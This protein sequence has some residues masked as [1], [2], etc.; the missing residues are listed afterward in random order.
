MNTSYVASLLERLGWLINYDKSTLSPATRLDFLG[1]TVDTRQMKFFVPALKRKNFRSSCQ[2]VLA[3]VSR[4]NPVRLRTFASLAG[5]LQSLAPA[6]PFCWLHLQGVIQTIRSRTEQK[7]SGEVQW[8]D[9]VQIPAQVVEELRWW[10]LFLKGWN[11]SAIIPEPTSIDLYSDA[12][13]TGYGG[14]LMEK[15]KQ[16]RRTVQGHWS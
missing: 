5:K 9:L 16:N 11:G 15:G 12:S 10:V 1:F 7:R 14:F 8:D 3:K 6:V 2:R 4:G 13:N